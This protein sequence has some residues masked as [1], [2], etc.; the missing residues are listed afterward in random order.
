MP[1][2]TSAV[3]PRKPASC[4]L[5]RFSLVPAADS[6]SA[7][8]GSALSAALAGASGFQV[9][10]PNRASVHQ[11]V[12][13]CDFLDLTLSSPLRMVYLVVGR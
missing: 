11:Y 7:R 13:A 3:T 12:V 8:S 4:F 6:W 1:I 9:S 5:D 2:E 10:A